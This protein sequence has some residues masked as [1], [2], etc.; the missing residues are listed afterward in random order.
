MGE[1]DI[2]LT[3]DG[4][5]NAWRCYGGWSLGKELANLAEM[6]AIHVESCFKIWFSHGVE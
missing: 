2:R 5:R 3:V 1:V 4:V 6:L